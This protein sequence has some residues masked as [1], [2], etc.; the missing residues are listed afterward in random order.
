VKNIDINEELRDATLVE[1]DELCVLNR[2]LKTL[3]RVLYIK[4]KDCQRILKLSPLTWGILTKTEGEMRDPALAILIT[5][6]LR[7][8]DE[9]PERAVSYDFP[10]IAKKLRIAESQ[11]PMFTGRSNYTLYRWKK[12]PLPTNHASSILDIISKSK[13]KTTVSKLKS[14]IYEVSKKKGVNVDKGVSWASQTST[15]GE[16]E[17]DEY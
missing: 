13:T 16:G 1:I 3:S 9:W 12:G 6:Y 11:I 10:A 2:H 7:N 4:E 8:P 5:F 17:S 14:A 15:E